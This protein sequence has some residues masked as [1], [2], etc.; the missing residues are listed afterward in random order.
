MYVSGPFYYV[1]A[2]TLAK[3]E[4]NRQISQ[5]YSD[6][7]ERIV[8]MLVQISDVIPRFQ[9]YQ[10]L[11]P[12]HQRL[13][14]RMSE[15]YLSIITFCAKAK[16]VLRASSQWGTSFI[17]QLLRRIVGSSVWKPF[18]REFGGMMKT[19][20]QQRDSVEREADV[21]HMWLTKTN[22]DITKRAMTRKWLMSCRLT[23][24]TNR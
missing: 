5:Q 2:A 3:T 21:G 15:A 12:N 11:F 4:P 24:I 20:E 22:M 14:I 19:F 6:Y 13:L 9:D 18:G 23:N 10:E 17:P 7:F 16:G 1:Q 8:D